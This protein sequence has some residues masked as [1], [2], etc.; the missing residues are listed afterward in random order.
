MPDFLAVWSDAVFLEHHAEGHPERPE[1]LSAITAAA[2]EDGQLAGVTWRSAPDCR[3]DD[4]TAV[5]SAAH[6]E[7]IAGLAA[8]GGGWLDPDTYCA[9][10]SYRVARLAAG[11][12]V[13]AVDAVCDGVV[14]TG[15]VLA[16][17]PGHHAGRDTPM[18]FCLFN[19]VAIAIE[20][21]RRRHGLQRVAIVD[22][23]V[24]HG[25]GT[26][27]IFAA[28]PDVL[29][30]SLH[31]WPFYP[32]TGGAE[33]RGVGAG[34]GATLNIPLAEG[35]TSDAWLS[36]LRD[37]ILPVVRRHQPELIMVSAGYDAHAADPIGGLQVSTDAYRAAAE[38]IAGVAHDVAGG[39]MVWA[40]EGGYD[41]E[42]LAS[43]VPLTMRTLLGKSS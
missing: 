12:G 39:R 29:Y 18:G 17:P 40:L 22:I 15:F 37:V 4:L 8:S 30:T 5:H 1:R 28:D 6:V 27:D 38:S 3:D 9:P 35:V 33:E 19:N 31:Q 10:A 25:N 7:R 13:D 24:H 26:Q 34:V 21:A 42:A 20:A 23:D 41:L 2:R 32:G 16:R 14:G 36:A 43:A 11:A